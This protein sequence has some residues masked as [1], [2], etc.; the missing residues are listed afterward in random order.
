MLLCACILIGC[1]IKAG[2]LGWIGIGFFAWI[3]TGVVEWDFASPKFVETVLTFALEVILF[4]TPV[5]FL[6]TPKDPC[7]GFP[8]VPDKLV[9]T[10][11]TPATFLEYEGKAAVVTG[12]GT[13]V[14]MASLG[15]VAPTVLTIFTGLDEVL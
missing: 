2:F 15:T 9:N 10:E 11:F 8:G 5:A 13:E 4:L 12:L 1:G 7:V 14:C 3:A 6:L